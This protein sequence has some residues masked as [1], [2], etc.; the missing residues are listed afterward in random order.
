M[1]H[2]GPPFILLRE[3]TFCWRPQYCEVGSKEKVRFGARTHRFLCLSSA[4]QLWK[5]HHHCMD[6]C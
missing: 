6:R 3:D 1:L 2:F 5:Q 4:V